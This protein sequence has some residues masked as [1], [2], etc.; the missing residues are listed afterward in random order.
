MHAWKIYNNFL[1]FFPILK[2][3][4]LTKTFAILWF[5]SIAILFFFFNYKNI[6]LGIL[7]LVCVCKLVFVSFSVYCL[8]IILKYKTNVDS[9]DGYIHYLWWI[10]FVVMVRTPIATNACPLTQASPFPIELRFKATGSFPIGA[11]KSVCKII[12]LHYYTY[13]LIIQAY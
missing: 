4:T 13:R 5:W 10:A 9:Y 12:N 1:I 3:W 8:Y 6:F 2:A 11:S 7:S